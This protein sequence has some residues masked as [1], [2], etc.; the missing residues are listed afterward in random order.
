MAQVGP[1][2]H[3]AVVDQDDI[4]E[5]VAGHIGQAHTRVREVDI[6]EGFQQAFLG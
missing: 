5:A 3:V 6:G 4:L 2:L 1:I